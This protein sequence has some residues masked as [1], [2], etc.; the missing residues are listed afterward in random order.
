MTQP[1]EDNVVETA[2][3]TIISPSTLPADTQ[4][5]HEDRLFRHF[6]GWLFSERANGTT[7]WT[8]DYGYDI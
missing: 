2:G 5:L 8:W 1:S 3:P 7:S 6:C 4:K